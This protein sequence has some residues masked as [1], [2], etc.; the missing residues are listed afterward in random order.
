MLLGTS[1]L[2]LT[3]TGGDGE[4]TYPPTITIH[5]TLCIGVRSSGCH[6]HLL[7]P[8]RNVLA[9]HGAFLIVAEAEEVA[10]VVV[11]ER[12]MSWRCVVFVAYGR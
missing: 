11:S 3:R 2:D 10:V 4:P 9:Y 6:C 12:A 5:T 8:Y 1:S 7:V